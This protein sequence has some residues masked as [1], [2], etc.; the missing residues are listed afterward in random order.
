M[1]FILAILM[2]KLIKGTIKDY[3][4]FPTEIYILGTMRVILRKIMV[5]TTG[6]VV[7]ITEVSLCQV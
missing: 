4:F 3:K 5:N 6:L 2:N 7:L 1:I